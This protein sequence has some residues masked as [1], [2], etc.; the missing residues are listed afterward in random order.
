MHD[1]PKKK[2]KKLRKVLIIVKGHFSLAILKGNSTDFT[3]S[4]QFNVL[5]RCAIT[6]LKQLYIIICDSQGNFPKSGDK[7]MSFSCLTKMY[8]RKSK[9]GLY[10]LGDSIHTSQ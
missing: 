2:K 10:N 4:D 1:Y 8:N 5:T 7:P 6:F 9:L 3:L